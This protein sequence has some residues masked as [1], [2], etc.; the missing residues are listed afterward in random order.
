[1]TNKDRI[2]CQKLYLFSFEIERIR[3]NSVSR[4]LRVIRIMRRRICIGQ[5]TQ[6]F[7]DTM[8]VTNLDQC[9]IVALCLVYR[10]PPPHRY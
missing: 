8:R 7:G 10:S 5:R 4:C 3:A 1:M 2:G 9:T 6:P